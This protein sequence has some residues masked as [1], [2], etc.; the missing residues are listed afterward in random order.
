MKFHWVYTLH[1]R[2]GLKP[3]SKWP[4]QNE[5]NG[6]FGSLFS[7]FVSLS[8]LFFF[9]TWLVC[10]LH[11]YLGFWFCAS[12]G[13]VCVS[14]CICVSH[15]F[16]SV[17]FWFIC[18]IIFLL[19][20]EREKEGM[21]LDGWGGSKRRWWRE[22]HE[23]NIVYGKNISNKWIIKLPRRH[24]AEHIWGCFQWGL[25]KEGESLWWFSC[26]ETSGLFLKRDKEE[27]KLDVGSWLSASIFQRQCD[28]SPHA[29][30]PWLLSHGELYSSCES[31]IFQG[32]WSEQ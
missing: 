12:V 28:R 23:Q 22:N 30:P 4:R 31:F 2:A 19:S 9:L 27:R 3:K 15:T 10:C 32:F 5:L 6:I 17:Y 11:I 16:F 24:N 14:L 29:L 1:S 21:E 7:S 13:F 25:N 18:F 26:T 20:K 8:G